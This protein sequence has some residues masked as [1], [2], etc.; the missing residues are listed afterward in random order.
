MRELA[1]RLHSASRD[2]RPAEEGEGNVD[3][4]GNDKHINGCVRGL[5]RADTG[6][7]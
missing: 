7:G 2:W 1:V 6:D 5:R 3:D 4:G